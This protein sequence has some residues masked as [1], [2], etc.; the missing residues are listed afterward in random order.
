MISIPDEELFSETTVGLMKNYFPKRQSGTPLHTSSKL[1]DI[2]AGFVT[3][4]P[5][6]KGSNLLYLRSPMGG[7]YSISDDMSCCNIESERFLSSNGVYQS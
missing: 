7:C 2:P 4:P 5:F 3:I 6:I 1:Y